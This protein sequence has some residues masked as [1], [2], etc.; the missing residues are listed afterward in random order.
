M[1]ERRALQRASTALEA[2]ET[3][4]YFGRVSVAQREL[5]V[6]NPWDAVRNLD[7]CKPKTGE[8]DRRSWE[9]H[10][11]KNAS[12]GDVLS[13]QASF[14]WV[15]DVAY[16]PDGTMLA[17]AAGTPY[18]IRR[19]NEPGELSLWDANTG[20]LIRRF[21]GHAGSIKRV[22]FSPDG[23]YLCTA[24][25]DKTV[26]V[27]HVATGES[28]G[29]AGNCTIHNGYDTFGDAGPCWFTADSRSVEF[30]GDDHWNRY[31]IATGQVSPL[32]NWQ[33]I[34]WQSPDRRLGL[35]RRSE[36][37]FEVMEF[38]SGKSLGIVEHPTG[39]GRAA[40]SA[41]GKQLVLSGAEYMEL[42]DVAT[43]RRKRIYEGADSWIE[44][45]AISGDGRSV[46][47][48]GSGRTVNVWNEGHH[49]AVAYAGHASEVR[50]LAFSPDCQRLAS[51]DRTGQ[52]FIWD[53]TRN[54]RQQLVQPG[55][56]ASGQAA[57]GLS[58][59]G[60]EIMTVLTDQRLLSHDLRGRRLR[61]IRI[62]GMTRKTEYPRLDIMF[63]PD[64]TRLSGPTDA[65]P[66]VARIWD[67]MTGHIVHE[68]RGH[69]YPVV[70]TAWS[71]DCKRLATRTQKSKKENAFA[72]VW[73][74]DATTGQKLYEVTTEP[75]EGMA[76]TSDGTRL[77]GGNRRG[78]VTMWDVAT[79]RELWRGISHWPDDY[80]GKFD[81]RLFAAAIAPN[82][83][84]MAT[85]GFLDGSLQLWK[86]DTGQKL[87]ASLHGNANLTGVTFTPDSQ[88]IVAAGYDA[89]TRMWDVATG[90]FALSLMIPTG[91]RRA[92][93]A[94]TARPVFSLTNQRLAVLN[95]NGYMACWDGSVKPE[96]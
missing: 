73:V 52:V 3:N 72:E 35:F 43:G 48:A 5:L 31:D 64:G 80:D 20:L 95:W 22:N 11:L 50:G 9:W 41:D 33:G 19:E 24:G 71:R 66:N 83:Q 13:I 62:D 28:I 84:V 61:E 96:K 36:F 65:E 55:C 18:S 46:A 68:L 58:C 67:T 2:A 59:D 87:H 51:C 23:R 49:Y 60:E 25:F 1:A 15:W 7:A 74:W 54:P 21:I 89:E 45:I 26:R 30:R 32:P 8:H 69:R 42:F 86:T 56:D 85:G 75:I 39:A 90:Q 94:Y 12:R 27:W 93:F 70:G 78:E 37:R 76:L 14:E 29:I 40:L 34:M 57:M 63:S 6:G 44:T 81:I 82:D 17:T 91:A 79:G 47:A 92:D 4:L 10:Y 16:S 38:A 88:R 53:L 77:G